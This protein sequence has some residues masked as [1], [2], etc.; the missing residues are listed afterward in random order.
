MFSCCYLFECF[1]L[2]LLVLLFID[3]NITV[4]KA[5]KPRVVSFSHDEQRLQLPDELITLQNLKRYRPSDSLAEHKDAFP[6]P[7][8]PQQAATEQLVISP[9]HPV[10]GSSH[11]VQIDKGGSLNC[12]FESTQMEPNYFGDT[13]Q[14]PFSFPS[15]AAVRAGGAVFLA[16]TQLAEADELEEQENGNGTASDAPLIGDSEAQ[17][18]GVEAALANM[19]DVYETG[20][21]TGIPVSMIN[22]PLA[23]IHINGGGTHVPG[24]ARQSPARSSVASLSNAE[25]GVRAAL[26][27]SSPHSARPTQIT[28]SSANSLSQSKLVAATQSAV[29]MHTQVDPFDSPD[30]AL[31]P[32]HLQ[33]TQLP[34]IDE[35]EEEVDEPDTSCNNSKGT[36]NSVDDERLL[37]GSKRAL[38]N[39]QLS[40]SDE[41]AEDEGRHIKRSRQA[42]DTQ[43]S[44]DR[45]ISGSVQINTP[46]PLLPVETPTILPAKATLS[47]STSSNLQHEEVIFDEGDAEG[48]GDDELEHEQGIDPLHHNDAP[49]SALREKRM[50]FQG[51]V[52]AIL[53]A[54]PSQ[55]TQQFSSQS[56]SSSPGRETVLFT[57][58]QIVSQSSSPQPTQPQLTAPRASQQ[59]STSRHSSS[60]SSSAAQPQSEEVQIQS[61]ATQQFISPEPVR[62]RARFRRSTG[63]PVLT[64]KKPINEIK[65]CDL[66]VDYI[67]VP[68]GDKLPMRFAPDKYAFRYDD[69]SSGESRYLHIKSPLPTR[70]NIV[71]HYAHMLK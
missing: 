56:S 4:T 15:T 33:H 62:P 19:S 40:P 61:E 43:L 60:S 58:R 35:R 17:A 23:S 65:L 42:Q 68:S 6:R 31:F 51:L 27:P 54:D 50:I 46:S 9:V 29:Y 47:L 37:S 8:Q 41:E 59:S 10:A 24:S 7:D 52:Q 3:G 67:A 22:A 44:Q 11:N 64:A 53:D 63:A 20:D 45:E 32:A 69:G 55:P 25:V 21:L 28:P 13:Q 14:L 1:T 48:Q 5:L 66:A 38:V 71:K 30:E 57:Q 39:T 70:N 26:I 12:S 34:P 18:N 49:S 16:S 36:E 2:L